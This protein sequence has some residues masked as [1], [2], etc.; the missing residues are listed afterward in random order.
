MITEKNTEDTLLKF[1]CDF[2]IKIIGQN[3]DSLEKNILTIIKKHV[4]RFPK[5][6]L[7][8]KLS[9]GG[10]FLSLTAVIKATSKKQLD[11]LYTELNQSKDVVT[12]L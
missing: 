4:K 3:N 7:T 5:K 6:N 10:K 11:A 1:P 8:K 12:T 9:S 2:P